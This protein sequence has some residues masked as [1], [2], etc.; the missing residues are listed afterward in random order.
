MD[1]WIIKRMGG[2]IGLINRM[3]GINELI[4]WIDG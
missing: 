1:G 2:L 3:D 4:E